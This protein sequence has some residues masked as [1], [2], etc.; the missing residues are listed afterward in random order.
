MKTNEQVAPLDLRP[1]SGVAEGKIRL[2][3]VDPAGKPVPGAQVGV[4]ANWSDSG[5]EGQAKG[6]LRVGLIGSKH[7]KKTGKNGTVLLRHQ[8]L[9]WEGWR[10]G[11]SQSLIVIHEERRIGAFASVCPSEAGRSGTLELQPLCRVHGK[12]TSTKL[13]KLGKKLSWTNM[14]LQVGQSR[15]VSCSSE[16]RRWEV[17][18]PPGEYLLDFYGTDTCGAGRRLIVPP[19]MRT[20]K[21]KVVD[22]LAHRLAYLYG[23]RAPEL[24]NIKA[25]KDNEAVS[26]R[27]LRGKV[28]ILDFWGVWCGPC[29]HS[30]PYLMALHDKYHDKGLEIIAVHD[31]RVESMRQLGQRCRRARKEIWGGRALPFRVAIDGDGQ[32]RI[33][34]FPKRFVASGPMVASYGINAFPTSLLIDKKG[35]LQRQIEVRVPLEEMAKVIEPLLES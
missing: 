18:V 9:F 24:R 30:M 14:Y 15:P 20:K 10:E 7:T 22:L 4:Y 23:K 17:L 12:L 34:G 16:R 32:A 21:A 5:R 2:K 6:G 19:G 35:I 25:W 8:E 27:S 1:D 28:V 29:V 26:L 31:N 13:A 3:V 11:R 33:P